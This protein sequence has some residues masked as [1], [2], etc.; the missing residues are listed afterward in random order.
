MAKDK[1]TP[2]RTTQATKT[3]AFYTECTVCGKFYPRGVATDY[4]TTCE[5]GNKFIVPKSR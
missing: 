1:A 3:N 2:Q 5:C 4:E